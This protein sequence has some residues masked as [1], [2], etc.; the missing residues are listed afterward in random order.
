MTKHDLKLWPVHYERVARMEKTFEIRLNDRAYQYGDL[1]MLSEYDP[2]Q[3]EYTDAPALHFKIGTVYPI[4]NNGEV[5]FSL[6]IIPETVCSLSEA[7]EYLKERGR[8]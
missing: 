3:L 2:D 8:A 6:M 5:V 7:K 4:G 1:V